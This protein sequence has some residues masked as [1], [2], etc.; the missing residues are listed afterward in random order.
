MATVRPAIVFE[1]V[2]VAVISRADEPSKLV[3]FPT[4]DT[5]V[6]WPVMMPL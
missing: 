6:C 1:P 2:V 5:T 4:V 3:M